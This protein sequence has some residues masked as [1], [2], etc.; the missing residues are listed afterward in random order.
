MVASFK[1]MQR[2][3]DFATIQTALE[4]SELLELNPQ[5]TMVK[6]K[7]PL[8]TNVNYSKIK[9]IQDQAQSRSLYS[10]SS[11]RNL[12]IALT[13]RPRAFANAPRRTCRRD[14]VKRLPPPNSTLKS[15]LSPMAQSTPFAYD[16]TSKKFS[17]DPCLLSSR[18]TT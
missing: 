5:K 4:T 3:K 2:F 14:L 13:F 12:S 11:I 16:E 10:V 6:R 15:C 8:D 17:K 1:R 7:V 18:M 9:E